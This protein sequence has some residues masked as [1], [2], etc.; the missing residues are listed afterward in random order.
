MTNRPR[1]R[2]NGRPSPLQRV[3][4]LR[5]SAA[6]ERDD[7]DSPAETGLSKLGIVVRHIAAPTT[8]VTALLFFFG[9]SH[10]FWFFDYF[11]VNST[12]LGL[13]TQDYLMRSQD[14]LFIPLAVLGCLL[15]AYIL[16]RTKLWEFMLPRIGSSPRVVTIGTTVVGLILV[17]IGMISIG[18]GTPFNWVVALPGLCIV[19]G[20]LL[21]AAAI[22][23]RRT[24]QHN[25]ESSAGSLS[26]GE[27]AA[28]FVLVG[29]GLFWAVA[30]YAAAVGTGRAMD[31]VDQ[32]PAQPSVLIH[33]A[34][35]LGLSG[36]GV[37]ELI[38]DEADAAYPFRYDG[39]KLVLQSG[40][41]YLLLPAEW[42][43]DTGVAFLLPRSDTIRLD[44]F[45]AGVAPPQ[46]CGW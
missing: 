9:W 17:G 20:A 15:T 10:A 8:L 21:I 22:R 31:Q 14:F 38:C 40:N 4:G 32:L 24:H 35:N 18:G 37:V 43:R 1:L 33:S 19:V 13:T 36:P 29:A 26:A 34:K 45:P 41:Q 42:S 7:T 2:G 28:V 12:T 44:F 39:L 30:D 3:A 23:L 5:P 25:V 46:R 16:F 11:G 6:R 27:W